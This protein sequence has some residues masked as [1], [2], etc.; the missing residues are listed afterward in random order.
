M[1]EYG[2]LLADDTVAPCSSLREAVAYSRG[3]DREICA[4]DG[5]DDEWSIVAPTGYQDEP[6][7][8]L[9]PG[10]RTLRRHEASREPTCDSCKKWKAAYERRRYRRSKERA[11]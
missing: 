1:T 10:H 7:D 9:I 3:A 8:C 2:V 11:A 6:V 5:Y 4:R